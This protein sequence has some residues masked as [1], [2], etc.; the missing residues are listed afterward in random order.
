MNES[1]SEQ[2][3][4]RVVDKNGGEWGDPLPTLGDAQRVVALCSRT[5]PD[6]APF[7]VHKVTTITEV[8]PLPEPEPKR[9][10]HA[11]VLGG[12]QGPDRCVWNEGH[13]GPHQTTYRWPNEE[14]PL[15][16]PLPYEYRVVC[17]NGYHIWSVYQG[18]DYDE[19]RRAELLHRA[20]AENRSGTPHRL[21]RRL[22]SGWED[23]NRE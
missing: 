9:C 15:P 5:N 17:D 7:S 11:A 10:H 22:I 20:D 23:W 18:S 3:V 16:E 13:D 21:Q 12:A 14:V 1:V 19:K 8:V 2:T 6:L 4:Y